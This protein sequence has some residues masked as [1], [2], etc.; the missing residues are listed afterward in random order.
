MLDISLF[1]KQF[2]GKVYNI[3]YIFLQNNRSACQNLTPLVDLVFDFLDNKTLQKPVNTFVEP[4]K[5]FKNLQNFIPLIINK[6][7]D[8]KLIQTLPSDY[9]EF[10]VKSMVKNAKVLTMVLESGNPIMPY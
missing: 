9:Y 4:L 8:L 1:F 3:F 5:K 7:T 6:I 2:E 10:T